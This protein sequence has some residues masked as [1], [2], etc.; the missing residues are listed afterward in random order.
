MERGGGGRL[1]GRRRR[2]VEYMLG[3][4]AWLYA[5]IGPVHVE[6]ATRAW[7]AVE[8]LLAVSAAIKLLV[9]TG[10]LLPRLYEL[11]VLHSRRVVLLESAIAAGYLDAAETS[12]RLP[13]GKQPVWR[14]VEKGLEPRDRL[15]LHALYERF[16]HLASDAMGACRA[17]PSWIRGE[18]SE[19]TARLEKLVA[20]TRRLYRR[21]TAGHRAPP[22][23]PPCRVCA[24]PRVRRVY[25][26]IVSRLSVAEQLL[27][28]GRVAIRVVGLRDEREA[29]IAARLYAQ[30]LYELYV[31]HTLLRALNRLKPG[32]ARSEKSRVIV[33]EYNGGLI[34]FY[35]VAPRFDDQLLSRVA[36]GEAEPPLPRSVLEAAA[37]RPDITLVARE[38]G[39][40]RVVAVIEAK[41]SRSPTYLTLARFKAIAYIHEYEASTG[42]L[43]YPG[44]AAEKPEASLEG[45]E[46]E[47]GTRLLAEAE[48]HGSLTIRLKNNATLHILPLPPTPEGEERGVEKLAGI[49]REAIGA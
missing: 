36:S 26:R 23:P 42:I 39:G 31:L 13:L 14:S 47:E 17:A 33:Y 29:R 28:E 24:A 5:L 10:R 3:R 27:R 49:L 4:V 30:R 32:E 12:R 34:I 11:A 16:Q 22:A 15:H 7:G 18:L 38:E 6:E 44:G 43:V 41:Y 20:K 1:Q 45:E 21:L 40:V 25:A 2:E 46:A 9:E 48:K 37:G 8:G 19:L 35:N